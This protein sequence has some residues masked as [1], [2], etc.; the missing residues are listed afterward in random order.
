M[1]GPQ[2]AGERRCVYRTQCRVGS[3]GEAN[4]EIKGARPHPSRWSQGASQRTGP[5]R[6][7]SGSRLSCS[8]RRGLVALLRDE[9]FSGPG[10]GGCG[11]W[12][13]NVL[14]IGELLDDSAYT[15]TCLSPLRPKTGLPGGL[16]RLLP[17]QAS[18]LAKPHVTFAAGHG[19]FWGNRIKSKTSQTGKSVHIG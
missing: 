4:S 5:E 17:P 2:I 1:C 15:T 7:G 19:P 9:T 14:L 16:A 12:G 6:R 8:P 18:T 3:W 10:K 13:Q 11:F